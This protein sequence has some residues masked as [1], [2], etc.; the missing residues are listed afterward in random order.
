MYG[1]VGGG[2]SSE[3]PLKDPIVADRPLN[4]SR[5]GPPPFGEDSEERA[6]LVESV[7]SRAPTPGEARFIDAAARAT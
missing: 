2:A 6:D 7:R 1:G 4:P 3:R 5:I